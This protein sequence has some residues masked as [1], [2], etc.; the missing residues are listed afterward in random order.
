MLSL[1]ATGMPA[2]CPDD[3]L[4][5]ISSARF[6]APSRSISR[7][8]FKVSLSF[9][10]A[11]TEN[12]T[13]LRDMSNFAVCD[14]KAATNRRRSFTRLWGHENGRRR[15]LELPPVL[16]VGP[17]KVQFHLLVTNWFAHLQA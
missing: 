11:L 10:A 15:G 9:S 2:S 7:K 16:S 1:T 12:S 3:A 4:R 13:C 14:H 5:S 17:V 8:A 6:R